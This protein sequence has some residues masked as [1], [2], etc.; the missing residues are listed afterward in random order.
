M[1]IQHMAATV[2]LAAVW[3]ALGASTVNVTNRYAYAANTGWIDARADTANGAVIG[4]YVCSN[5]LYAANTGWIHLGD[6]TPANGLSY[7]NA[8]AADYGVNVSP[9][10]LLTGYAWSANTGW[11]TFEQT[12]GKPS[13][14]LKT[15]ALQGSA[16]S[17]NAGWISLSNAYAFV[18]TDRLG[19]G[20][21]TDGDGL[22]DPWEYSYT[23]TLAGLGATPADADGDGSPD[24]DEYGA[25]TDPTDPSDLLVITAW[26]ATNLPSASLTW[27]STDTRFY[28]VKL[29]Y[30]LTNAWSESSLGLIT[31]PSTPGTTRIL[32]LSAT[33]RLFLRVQSVLPLSP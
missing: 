17:A 4:R 9:Y 26:T 8:S 23:N 31:D 1:S 12:Y 5:Y 14:D 3:A 33:N 6:G 22:P 30:N 7:G 21:D 10:G 29:A 25:G 27:A 20:P 18:Q 16:W 24:S 2:W 28:R 32:S 11:I 13:V 15:G 19:S